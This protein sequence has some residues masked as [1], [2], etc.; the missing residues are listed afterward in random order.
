MKTV[1][2]S[3]KRQR[4]ENKTPQ[5][6][7]LFVLVWHFGPQLLLEE[8]L[9]LDHFGPHMLLEEILSLEQMSLLVL[10]LTFVVAQVRPVEGHCSLDVAQVQPGHCSLVHSLGVNQL[11]RQ[12]LLVH[13]NQH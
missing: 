10:V 13:P 3:P 2:R 8:I 1:P 7:V 6:T 9:P 5:R 11:H 4:G 12:H